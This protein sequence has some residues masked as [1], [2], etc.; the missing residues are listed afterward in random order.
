MSADRLRQLLR[1]CLVEI[2][3]APRDGDE[4]SGD[5]P[6]AGSGFFVAPGYVFTC[7]HVARRPRGSRVTGTWQGT[8]WSGVVE[9]TDPAPAEQ[10]ITGDGIWPLPDLAVIRLETDTRH[11]CVRLS[12]RDPHERGSYFVMGRRAPLGG[13]PGDFPTSDLSYSGVQTG[14]GVGKMMRLTGESLEE[15]MS[16]GP[17]LNLDI[18]EVC[19]LLK[20]VDPHGTPFVVPPERL[21]DPGG[22][23]GRLL[24][25]ILRSHDRYHES[26]GT[27]VLAQDALWE[28]RSESHRPPLK[29]TEEAG[30]L[31][32][33]AE[34]SGTGSLE[35]L[36]LD[37]VDDESPYP[38]PGNLR[39]VRDLVFRLYD[40]PFARDRLHPVI[41]LAELLATR[42]GEAG[43]A[44]RLRQW[45]AGVARRRG[46]LE[47]LLKWRDQPSSPR[48]TRTDPMSVVI[49]LRHDA[50][51]HDRLQVTVWQNLSRNNISVV[52]NDGTAR[53]REEVI[54]LLAERLPRVIGRF[55]DGPAIIEFILTPELYDEAVHQWRVFEK[56][57]A[58]LGNR[59]PVVVRDYD[60]VFD[61]A[62]ESRR[63]VKAKWSSLSA[64]DDTPVY[65]LT[66][67]SSPT[68][69]EINDYFESLA[70]H[71][72]K[73]FGMPGPAANF[74]DPLDAAIAAGT[75][76]A[77]WCLSPCAQHGGANADSGPCDG[78][79][80]TQEA[81]A[82]LVSLDLGDWPERMRQLR[83]TP[84]SHLADAQLLW[85]NPDRGPHPRGLAV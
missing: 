64:R 5:P 74:A 43:L 42:Q 31:V 76:V 84:A 79:R 23:D 30:L 8:R 85:D 41:V 83:A 63:H 36:Y 20:S 29:P 72:A 3:D 24:A 56:R 66:C 10:D 50:R 73:A 48:R 27:W 77:L 78:L 45:S 14:T 58:K 81:I 55:G 80:F 32:L 39:T 62:G 26:D 28:V 9:Y 52:F 40:V 6:P 60:R 18:G 57:R 53:T 33:L 11:P 70:P 46:E 7:A 47:S 16:G 2:N 49:A 51:Q 37:C 15:G 61:Q 54:A 68:W 17:A 35:R 4:P 67:E 34:A 65:W 21:H 38:D 71:Q 59:Y 25:D 82:Q 44:P 13:D 1:E 69:D 22:Q 12:S 75:P 19:G